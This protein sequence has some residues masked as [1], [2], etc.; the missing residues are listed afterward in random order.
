MAESFGLPRFICLGINFSD[1]LDQRIK[2]DKASLK[3]FRVI[4]WA[5]WSRGLICGDTYLCTTLSVSYEVV[6][7]LGSFTIGGPICGIL[8]SFWKSGK[9]SKRLS[10]TK[11]NHEKVATSSI[12]SWDF[13]VIF[14]NSSIWRQLHLKVAAHE[15][16]CVCVKDHRTF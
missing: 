10:M 2:L 7:S 8:K 15:V 11:S 13:L 5:Y 1:H 9:F 12:V 6:F 3:I 4:S 14:E 16:F